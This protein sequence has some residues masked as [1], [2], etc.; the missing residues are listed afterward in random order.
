MSEWGS[1]NPADNWQTIDGARHVADPNANYWTI[2]GVRHPLFPQQSRLDFGTTSV[3]AVTPAPTPPQFKFTFDTIGQTIVRS[4]GHC[5][6]RLVPIW[7]Q[8]ISESGDTSISST[9]TFAGALSAPIDPLEDGEIFAV[10]DG[11]TQVL[12]S[13]GVITPAG[14]TP[15]DAALLAASLAGVVIYPGDEAQLP[16]PLIVADKGADKTNAFRGIRYVIVPNYPINGGG[17][18]SGGLPQLSVGWQRTKDGGETKQQQRD[19]DRDFDAVEF[20]AGLD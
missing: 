13:G 7:A 17:R 9:Q 4:I 3:P 10:W 14:W 11:G 15:E 16:A 8:G 1:G 5:R 2:N 18:G 12:N 19:R 6:L 20:A